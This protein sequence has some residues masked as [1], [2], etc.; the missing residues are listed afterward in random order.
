MNYYK[1]CPYCG[2]HLDPGEVC[3]CDKKEAVVSATNADNG[4]A[5]FGNEAHF[6]ASN[7]SDNFGG[8]KHE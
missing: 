1:V 2:C 3:D 6:P 8:F 4:K 7:I 5:G